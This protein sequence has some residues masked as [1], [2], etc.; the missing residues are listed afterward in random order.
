MIN[1]LLQI[2]EDSVHLYR[3]FFVPENDPLT[4]SPGTINFSRGI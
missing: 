1:L 3:V 4:P 2:T